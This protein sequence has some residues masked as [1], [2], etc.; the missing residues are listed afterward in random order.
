MF[1]IFVC[2][3]HRRFRWFIMYFMLVGKQICLLA[4][5]VYETYV[6]LWTIQFG[7]QTDSRLFM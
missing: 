1:I 2:G 6:V 7:I 3:Q 4:C 5:D